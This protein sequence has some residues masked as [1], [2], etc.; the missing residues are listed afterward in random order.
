M[1]IQYTPNGNSTYKREHEVTVKAEEAGEKVK[2]IKYQWLNTTVQPSKESFSDTVANGE[3]V[4]KNKV[5]GQWYLWTLLETESGKTSIQRSEAFY[6][7]NEGPTVNITST[8]VSEIA[9]TLLADATDDKV[10]IAKYEYYVNG[11]LKETKLPTDSDISCKV[12][13]AQTGDTECYVVVTDTLGNQTTKTVTGKT[14]LYTWE[15]WDTKP[16]YTFIFEET[17]TMHTFTANTLYFGIYFD[18]E[19]QGFCTPRR[20]TEVKKGDVENLRKHIGEYMYDNGS[21]NAYLGSRGWRLESISNDYWPVARAIDAKRQEV[22]GKGDNKEDTDATVTRRNQYP[23]DAV[24]GTKYYIY[25]G[26]Y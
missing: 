25:K 16:T 22:L 10:D 26:V 24:S 15:V 11:V 8:P 1:S 2:S 12:T 21:T 7:D 20:L 14:K 18:E 13:D 6:F 4:T 19:Q 9:F 17:D 5:T 3:K 23:D